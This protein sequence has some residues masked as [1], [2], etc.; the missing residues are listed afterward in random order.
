MKMQSTSYSG[1]FVRIFLRASAI[2]LGATM[3]V[4]HPPVEWSVGEAGRTSAHPDGGRA[5]AVQA[6]THVVDVELTQTTPLDEECSRET[7]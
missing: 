6:R 1:L 5:R 2:F 7:R 3:V 4:L